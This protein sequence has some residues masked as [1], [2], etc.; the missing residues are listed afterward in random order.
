VRAAAGGGLQLQAVELHR[1]VHHLRSSACAGRPLGGLRVAGG[2][3]HPG[4]AGQDLD[5]LHEA[6][7]FGFLDEGDGIALRVAAEA[8]VIALAVIDMERLAD[9]S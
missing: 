9:F 2:H 5:R 4:L 7:V 1:L 3:L 8:V 6:E